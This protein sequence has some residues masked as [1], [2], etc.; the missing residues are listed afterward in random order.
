M[1][2]AESTG[3]HRDEVVVVHDEAGSRYLGRIGNEAV[4]VI[5]YHLD[6]NTVVVTH[7]GTE[8]RWRGRGVAGRL[9]RF[10]LDDIRASGRQVRPVCPYT[11]DYLERHPEDRDLVA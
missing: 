8:P 4:G 3:S 1:T 7:T 9:T 11:A 10:A 5:T 6:G 2:D